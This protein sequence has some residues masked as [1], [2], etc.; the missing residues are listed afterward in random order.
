M[1]G[2]AQYLDIYLAPLAQWLARNDVTDVMINRPGEAWIETLGGTIERVECPELDA[3][4]L[5]HL[6]RQVAALSHQ[7]ISRAHPLLAATL[8]D[9]ARVQVVAPPATRGDMAIA[10]RKHLAPK[11]SLHDYV[12]DGAFC[13][14][15]VSS[16]IAAPAPSP[17]PSGDTQEDLS[18]FLS[19]LVGSR[20]NVLISGGTSSGKTT[21][22]NALM[23]EIPPQE[24]I[25][26]IEDTAEIA[27]AHGNAIG[28]LATKGELGEARVSA[29]DLLQAALRMRPDRIVVGELRGAEAYTFLRAINTGHPG[30]LST[31]HA[32]SP[33]GAIEQLALII[34]QT[35]TQLRREDIVAY[36][37]ATVDVIV[38]L[39]RRN[40]V[41]RIAAIKLTRD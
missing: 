11:R 3:G 30:S 9:G 41:R 26:L 4:R 10:F 34:L 15:A 6:V 14:A 39:E 23:R 32:D 18:R 8:P 28:L 16:G 29:D 13:D 1:E 24:R 21:F 38:Q 19:E 40:G 25:V 36:V 20:R 5:W 31:I 7:G 17:R 33:E 2:R 37:T 35:G 12:A 27:L 22:L